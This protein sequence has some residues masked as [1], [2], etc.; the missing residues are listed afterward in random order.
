[1]HMDPVV[2]SIVV[3]GIAALPASIAAWASLAARKATT[4]NGGK[5]NPP[6]IP[7]KIASL[8][9][10][11]QEMDAKLDLLIVSHA[12]HLAWSKEETAR[13]WQAN[14]RR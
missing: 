7:D 4:K 2:G 11:Q 8:S 14:L 12:E 3:A 10:Q 9:A 6:T 1:M 13:L 5:N